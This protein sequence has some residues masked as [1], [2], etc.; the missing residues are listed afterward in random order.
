MQDSLMRPR[1]LIADDHSMV[2]QRLCS[3]L[4]NSCDVIGV[5]ENG[6]RLLTDGPGLKPDV[7][8]LDI[9][10]PLLSGLD[11]AERLKQ[12]LP[13]AKFVFLTMN[14][15]HNL[16][17]AALKL[18]PVG[19]VLKSEAVLELRAAIF[20]VLQDKAHVTTKLRKLRVEGATGAPARSPESGL[21]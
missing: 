2:G 15:D 17:E 8:V 12:L 19:Y 5:V 4:K 13:D 20:D 16:A 21:G 18:G 11:A 3:L 1:V 9:S 14:A 7:I 10:M 6:Q